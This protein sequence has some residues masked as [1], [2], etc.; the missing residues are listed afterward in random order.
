MDSANQLNG[1]KDKLEQ[2]HKEHPRL[3]IPE[4]LRLFYGLDWV[5]GTGG[6]ISIK[7]E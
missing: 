2:L 5:T 6:G 7:H 4:L 3:L 1:S